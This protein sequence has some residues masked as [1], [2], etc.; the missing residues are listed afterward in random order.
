MTENELSKLLIGIFIKIH[1][2]LGLGLLESVYEKAICYELAKNKIKF[3]KQQAI[4]AF[5]DG[6][7]LDI[8]FRADI[9]V[10]DKVLIELKSI[11][12]ILPLH[13]KTT[14]TYLRLTKIKLGLLVNFNVGLLKD[15]IFRVVNNLETN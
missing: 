1:K 3:T 11:E 10:D 7:K 8:G 13:H 6:V 14:L 4:P 15:G 5:Y 12:H 9:I 2:E